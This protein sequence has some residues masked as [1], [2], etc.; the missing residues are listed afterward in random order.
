MRQ[1]GGRPGAVLFPGRGLDRL[2]FP[3]GWE[4]RDLHHAPGRLGRDPA[5]I[6]PAGGLAAALGTVGLTAGGGTGSKRQYLGTFLIDT[7]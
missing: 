6:R 2:H 7:F 3:P 4:G 1:V 5:D